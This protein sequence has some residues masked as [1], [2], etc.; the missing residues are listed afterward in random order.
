MHFQNQDC[1]IYIGKIDAFETPKNKKTIQSSRYCN[2]HM[3]KRRNTLWLLHSVWIQI[4]MHF[5]IHKN[6]LWKLWPIHRRNTKI[7]LFKGRTGHIFQKRGHFAETGFAI[8]L[9]SRNL[10]GI[11]TKGLKKANNELTI[12]EIHY[13]ILKLE[14]HT[15]N[16]FLKLIPN[17]VKKFKKENGKVDFSCIQKF[18]GKFII[19]N[20]ITTGIRNY[21]HPFK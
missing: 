14:K 15:T 5:T 19:Q 1:Q 3:R 7:L 12:S 2:N 8:L 13:N 4:R 10:R 6:L 21:K 16:K 9:E 11:K 18:K 17:I 20:D